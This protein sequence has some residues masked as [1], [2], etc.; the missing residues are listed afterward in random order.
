[1]AIVVNPFWTGIRVPYIA[2]VPP[3]LE[4]ALCIMRMVVEAMKRRGLS[5]DLILRYYADVTKC[6]DYNQI[7]FISKQ[8]V[9]LTEV[10]DINRG[11]V[12]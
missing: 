3:T 7:I 11:K 8:W 9:D 10:R 6:E 12:G 4:N 1:M 2:N 5:D